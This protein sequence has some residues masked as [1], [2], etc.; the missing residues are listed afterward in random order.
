MMQVDLR[1]LKCFD[2]GTNSDIDVISSP[3]S[4]EL[5]N[6]IISH[7]KCLTCIVSGMYMCLRLRTAKF[8]DLLTALTIPKV[9]NKERSEACQNVKKT[10]S[11][12]SIGEAMH[13]YKMTNG[14]YRQLLSKRALAMVHVEPNLLR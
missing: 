13:L 3:T 9:L 10:S 6:T 11:R 4:L 8:Y 7:Q 5:V 2:N 12:K 1:H 14:T